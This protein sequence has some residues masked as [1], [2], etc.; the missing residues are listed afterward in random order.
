MV[1]ENRSIA[2]PHSSGRVC[3]ATPIRVEPSDGLE[4]DIMV[5]IDRSDGRG[6]P[7]VSSL[8]I[9]LLGKSG[10]HHKRVFVHVSWPGFVHEFVSDHIAVA[11]ESLR[12]L[13]PIVLK[14]S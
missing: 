2:V 6:D 13:F 8:Q 14:L 11:L 7:I 4:A 10:D 5:R 3:E 1:A 9:I 12:H